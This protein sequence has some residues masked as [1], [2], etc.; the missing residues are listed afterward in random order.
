MNTWFEVTVKYIK[1]NEQGREKKATETYLLDAVSFSEAES[2]I[3]NELEKMIS[4][5]FSVRKIAITNISEIIPSENGDRYFKGKVSFITIDE[6]SGKEKRI[7]QNVLVF[8]NSVDEADKNIKEA[9]SGMM[10]DFEITAIIE[11]KIVDVFPYSGMQS[12]VSVS[13]EGFEM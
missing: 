9:M 5:E 3:Y 1:L 8:A 12:I 7:A 11:S 4:D 2:R 6:Q 13:E 10:A